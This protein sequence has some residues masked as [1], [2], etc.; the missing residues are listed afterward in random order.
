MRA[1][2]PLLISIF[3]FIL[4]SNTFAQQQE[5]R[6]I[7]RYQ[8]DLYSTQK[9]IKKIDGDIITLTSKIKKLQQE[10]TRLIAAM[11]KWQQSIKKTNSSS[12]SKQINAKI[13]TLQKL[14]SAMEKS[15]DNQLKIYI[16]EL[17]IESKKMQRLIQA[18]KQIN[19]QVLDRQKVFVQHKK[20][21]TQL[22][23]KIELY[24][25]VLAKKAKERQIL[26]RNVSVYQKKIRFV[27]LQHIENKKKKEK[28]RKIAAAYIAKNREAAKNKAAQNNAQGRRRNRVREIP[29]PEEEILLLLGVASQIDIDNDDSSRKKQQSSNRKPNAKDGAPMILVA[30]AWIYE[31]PVTNEQY[32]QKFR[33]MYYNSSESKLPVTQISFEDAQEYARWAGGTLMTYTQLKKLPPGMMTENWEWTRSS[34]KR[35]NAHVIYHNEQK[36]RLLSDA[37]ESTQ[38]AFRVIFPRK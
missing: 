35:P 18:K 1:H 11:T 26:K 29:D 13:Y 10:K 15:S 38:V 21:A 25:V 24:K 5:K 7:K 9:S 3:F 4:L 6:V 23:K 28:K 20:Q 36:P 32:W 19:L 27:L 34:Y 22:S 31:K 14:T 37:Q 8:Q 2:N 16:Q 33:G 17:Q 12:V 30:G